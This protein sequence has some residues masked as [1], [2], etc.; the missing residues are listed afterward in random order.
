MLSIKELNTAFF[1]LLRDNETVYITNVANSAHLH[2]TPERPSMDDATVESEDIEIHILEEHY[3]KMKVEYKSIQSKLL[4]KINQVQAL[5][6]KEEE[7]LDG[8]GNLVDAEQL[9]VRLMALSCGSTL[10]LVSEE[11]YTLRKICEFSPSPKQ[12]N[13]SSLSGKQDGP[14]KKS[15]ERWQKKIYEQK[16]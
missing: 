7:W 11:A 15:V 8:D 1:K 5:T 9:I 2:L 10:K 6:N 13:A 3:K 14:K 16:G 4:S 12:E